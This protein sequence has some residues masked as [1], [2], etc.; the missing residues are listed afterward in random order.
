MQKFYLHFGHLTHRDSGF[1]KANSSTRTSVNDT[2]ESDTTQTA[3]TKTET[4]S[5]KSS[6]NSVETIPRSSLEQSSIG[7]ILCF[8][9]SHDG[10]AIS[11]LGIFQKN[12]LILLGWI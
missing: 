11:L 8:H 9:R 10:F 5:E 3:T 7:N 6:E 2:T 12:I 4:E 1:E